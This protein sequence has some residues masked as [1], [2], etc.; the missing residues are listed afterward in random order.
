MLM[1][2]DI[3]VVR[4]SD[5]IVIWLFLESDCRRMEHTERVQVNL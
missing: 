5:G 1:E 3:E 2:S 4:W